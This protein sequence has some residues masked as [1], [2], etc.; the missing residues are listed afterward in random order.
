M[1]YGIWFTP[2]VGYLRSYSEPKDFAEL[3]RIYPAL[4]L[5]GLYDP[6]V[7]RLISKGYIKVPNSTAQLFCNYAYF[8]HVAHVLL[9]VVPSITPINKARLIEHTRTHT[10][11]NAQTT[12]VCVTADS[13]DSYT[14]LRLCFC[15]V[16]TSAWCVYLSDSIFSREKNLFR[17]PEQLTA[18][19]SGT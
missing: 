5:C 14:Q 4:Y 2:S 8:G 1:V 6:S 16:Y 10:E 3:T 15:H 19:L 18:R 17:V 12:R 9:L 13:L 11:R 7:S